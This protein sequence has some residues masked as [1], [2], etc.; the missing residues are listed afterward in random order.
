[1]GDVDQATIQKVMAELGRRGGEAR[2]KNL[3]G[4]ERKRI[5]TKAS[6]AAVAART[7]KAKQKKREESA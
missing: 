3:S 7:R 5:A 6:K 2:A 4:K 1:M